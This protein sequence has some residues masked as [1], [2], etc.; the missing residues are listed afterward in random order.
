[1]ELMRREKRKKKEVW[2]P[3]KT[4]LYPNPNPHNTQPFPSAGFGLSGLAKIPHQKPRPEH[5]VQNTILNWTS[6]SS[7]FR[8]GF[9]MDLQRGISRGTPRGTHVTGTLPNNVARQF[10]MQCGLLQCKF[11]SDWK[12]TS[13]KL[14]KHTVLWD[15]HRSSDHKR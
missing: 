6:K 9:H 7:N 2:F 1:M 11:W 12:G 13:S 3:P 14:N 4:H 5:Y 8:F 10:N 15:H